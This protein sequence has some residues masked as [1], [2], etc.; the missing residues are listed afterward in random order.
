MKPGEI[1]VSARLAQTAAV[2]IVSSMLSLLLLSKVTPMVWEDHF[3][4]GQNLRSTGALTIDDVPS[5]IRP[6]GFPAFVAASLWIGDVL[7]ARKD[8]TDK[9]DP[10]RDRRTVVSAQCILLGALPIIFC[11]WC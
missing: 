10:D 1:S 3:E 7:S 11:L 6:P 8:T 4:I 9:R 2:F 5:L